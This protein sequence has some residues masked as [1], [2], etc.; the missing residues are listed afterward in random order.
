MA[1]SLKSLS[2]ITTAASALSGLIL[3]SPQTTVGIQPQNPPNA[4]GT[5]STAKQPESILFAYEGD[6]SIVLSSDITTHFV[7]DNTPRQDNISI[8]PEEYTVRSYVGELNDV[9]PLG[10]Q[11]IKTLSQ[12]LGAISSFTPGL[13][14]TALIAYQQAFFLYQVAASVSNSAV[15]SW[16]ALSNMLTN[17]NGQS[18]IG[19]TG[20]T[21]AKVQN[22]QQSKFQELY[23]YWRNRTLFT[24]QTPWVVFQ[25]MAIKSLRVIQ[26]D[27]TNQVSDFEI[28]F[29]T[30][31]FASTKITGLSFLDSRAS[32][33]AAAVKDFGAAAASPAKSF[34]SGL[35]GMFA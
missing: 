15:Q 11:T 10:L 28:T 22:K 25:N 23:G 24:V 6:Q 30:I 35:G 8:K 29:Q 18:V 16:T 19:S 3:V 14:T 9:A 32:T 21:K 27:T 34:A 4:D 31:R 33:Q 12:K 5:P 13:S 26:D 1:I 20:L 17:D 2:P 7:D